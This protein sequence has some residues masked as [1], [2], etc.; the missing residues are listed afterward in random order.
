MVHLQY[1]VVV[2][3]SAVVQQLLVLLTYDSLKLFLPTGLRGSASTTTLRMVHSF[4]HTK[5][6]KRRKCPGNSPTVEMVVPAVGDLAWGWPAE[7]RNKEVC[8]RTTQLIHV[9]DCTCA[10]KTSSFYFSRSINSKTC[11]VS[12]LRNRARATERNAVGSRPR[13]AALR[14]VRC[15]VSM[16]RIIKLP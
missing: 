9:A 7:K 16:C 11:Q 5:C 3:L 6:V 12:L 2:Q 10:L 15:I 1:R 4:S 8:S 13:G 14:R